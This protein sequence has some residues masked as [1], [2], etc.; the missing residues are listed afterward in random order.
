MCVSFV[1]VNGGQETSCSG[2]GLKRGLRANNKVW[3]EQKT[4]FWLV[5]RGT[6]S[7]VVLFSS[8]SFMTLLVSF[9]SNPSLLHFTTTLVLVLVLVPSSTVPKTVAG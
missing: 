8:P 4:S 6:R 9:S 2:F 5:V 3:G 1:S 7:L